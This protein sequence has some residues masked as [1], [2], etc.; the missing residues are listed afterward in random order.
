MFDESTPSPTRKISGRLVVSYAGFL[1]ESDLLEAIYNRGIAGS[2]VAPDLY[3][4][5]GTLCYWTHQGPAPWQNSRWYNELKKNE[6]PNAFLRFAENRW[7]SSES[8]FIEESA[9]DAIVD[10]TSTNG[11]PKTLRIRWIGREHP[12]RHHGDCCLRL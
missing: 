6:R 2:E 4:S 1:G 12:A 9:W 3:E 10:P 7:V 8:K 11:G 5:E